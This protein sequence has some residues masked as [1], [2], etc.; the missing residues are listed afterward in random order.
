MKKVRVQV[1]KYLTTKTEDTLTQ[2]QQKKRTNAAAAA[3]HLLYAQKLHLIG[4]SEWKRKPLSR[5]ITFKPK[6][7]RK[8]GVMTGEN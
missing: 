2:Q 6:Y 3:L 1:P 4:E 7:N 8:Y 5:L